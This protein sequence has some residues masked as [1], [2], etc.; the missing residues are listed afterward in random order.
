VV[1]PTLSTTCPVLCVAVDPTKGLL[2]LLLLLVR[3]TRHPAAMP[4]LTKVLLGRRL[5]EGRWDE[6]PCTLR[7]MLL[8]LLLLLLVRGCATAATA[9]STIHVPGWGW[10]WVLPKLW[11][12]VSPGRMG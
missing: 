10:G 2:L 6:G 4:R 12:A 9:A 1:A 7:A 3:A 8:L 11:R 5:V